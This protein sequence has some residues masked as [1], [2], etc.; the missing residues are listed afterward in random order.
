[1][2]Q[3]ALPEASFLPSGE[4]ATVK[5]LWLSNKTNEQGGEK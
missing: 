2:K 1:M 4:N 3:S 5:T